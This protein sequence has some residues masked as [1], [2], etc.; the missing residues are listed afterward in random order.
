MD[1]MTSSSLSLKGFSFSEL[2]TVDGLSKLDSTFLEFLKAANAVLHARLL[3]YRKRD[4]L[5]PQELSELLIEC[6][7]HVEAF[8][9]DLFFY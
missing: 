9:A 4:P 8:L 3:R 7:P 2:F 6:G 5:S 1:A